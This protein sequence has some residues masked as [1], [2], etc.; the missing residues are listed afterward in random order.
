[1]KKLLLGVISLTIISFAGIALAVDDTTV[2]SIQN[3]ATTANNKADQ[4][5]AEIQSM[6][7]GLPAEAAARIAEDAYL[8]TQID[9][10]QL[11]PG[12][13]CWDL[14]GNLY[15][16][17]E[18]DINGDNVWDTDDCVPAPSTTAPVLQTRVYSDYTRRITT[19]GICTQYQD[20][21]WKIVVQSF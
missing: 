15:S 6:K 11:I 14:N 1:M 21:I 19:N 17:P 8:Q 2:L 18:E 4:N 3:E 9:N 5:A 16:D 10:I 7:G 20:E 12:L 13:S